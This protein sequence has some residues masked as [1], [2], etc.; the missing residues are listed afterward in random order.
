MKRH[1]LRPRR[2]CVPHSLLLADRRVSILRLGWHRIWLCR[3]W[4]RYISILRRGWK[5]TRTVAVPVLIGLLFSIAWTAFPQPGTAPQNVPSNPHQQKQPPATSPYGQTIFSRSANSPNHPPAKKAASPQSKAH[6]T[7]LVTNA[8]RT[9]LTYIS[10]D[11]EVHLE[12]PQ[13]SLDARVLMVAQNSSDRPMHRIALQLSSS[14]HWYSISVNGR[15]VK[16]QTENVESDIDHTGQLTEAVVQLSSPLAPG[17]AIHLDTIYSGTISPSAQ[18]LVR[19]GAPGDVAAESE[20]DEITPEFTALR[21]FGNVIWFPVSTA[22]VLLGE[23]SQMFDSVGKWKLRES[24]A[25]VKMHVLVEYLDV[26]PNV[27]MLNGHIVHPGA[28]ATAPLI[29]APPNPPAFSSSSDNAAS[30]NEVANDVLHVESF[31]LPQTRLDFSPLSSFVLHEAEQQF[32]GLKIFTRTGNET[33]AAVYSRIVDGDRPLTQQWLGSHPKRSVVLVDLPG[34]DD[35]PFEQRNILFLPLDAGAS[36]DTAGPVM[37]HM[38][39]HSYFV[40]R[41]PW[42]NEGVAQF[43]TLLWIEQRAGRAT[44]IGQMDSR[45]AALALAETSDPGADPGQSLIDAWSDIY[46]R[47]KAADVLW[48]LRDIAGDAPLAK[49]LQAYDP[50]KDREPSDLQMLLQKF[51]GKDL[52]WFFDDWVYRDRGLPDLHIV[53]AYRRKILTQNSAATDYLV[54]VNVRNDGF[55]SAEVPVTVQSDTSTQTKRL[56][57]PA[58]SSASLR[59]VTDSKPNTVTVN[60]GSVPEV[61]ASHHQKTITAAQ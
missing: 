37:A 15:P 35:L 14:L 43:M 26:K 9:A 29:K 34:H 19:L 31:T 1:K 13:H 41:R 4:V 28:L 58:H 32:N 33:A 57:V 54:S 59:M 18:R 52:E 48:M 47:D 22:P 30:G 11:F 7:P 8:E 3:I 23:G 56:R 2:I 24:N 10:Y 42:L 6:A 12:P 55:C 39:S 38:L 36:R 25:T 51:S 27:A 16:F 5:R 21:G 46:Y 20:W 53:S 45:R 50:A 60:D 44:A 61:R 49:T 40:S 17:A